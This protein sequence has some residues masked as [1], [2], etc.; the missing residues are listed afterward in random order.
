MSTVCSLTWLD[1]EQQ[2]YLWALWWQ[3]KL[4]NFC[5]LLSV[6]SY[7]HHVHF[8]KNKVCQ[9]EKHQVMPTSLSVFSFFKVLPRLFSAFIVLLAFRSL[10]LCIWLDGVDV[11]SGQEDLRRSYSVS[12]ESKWT[13]FTFILFPNTTGIKIYWRIKSSLYLDQVKH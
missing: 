10:N 4:I 1:L 7:S 13:A 5:V 6:C 3:Q 2:L 12:W 8:S 9:G 11:I